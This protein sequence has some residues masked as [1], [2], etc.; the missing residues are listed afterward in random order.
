MG[1]WAKKTL[2][3][4]SS[5]LRNPGFVLG[6]LT[7]N[8]RLLPITLIAAV[9]WLATF[10]PGFWGGAGAWGFRIACAALWIWLAIALFRTPIQRSPLVA[11]LFLIVTSALWFYAIIPVGFASAVIITRSHALESTI[12]GAFYGASPN[13]LPRLIDSAGE[14]AVSR[15]S[16]AGIA[17][18][19]WALPAHHQEPSKANIMD[20]SLLPSRWLIIGL[21]AGS[22]VFYVLTRNN[23]F[24]PNVIWAEAVRQAN[25]AFLALYGA[26]I[27]LAVLRVVMRIEGAMVDLVIVAVAAIGFVPSGGAKLAVFILGTSGMAVALARRS[28]ILVVGAIAG[29]LAVMVAGV[30]MRQYESA[31][32]S[33]KINRTGSIL[34]AKVVARQAETTD[35]LTGVIHAYSDGREVPFNPFYFMAGLAPRFLWPDKPNLSAS[36]RIVIKYCDLN[37]RQNLTSNLSHS[38]SGTLLWEPLNFA[39][40]PGQIVAQTL[41]FLTLTLLSRIWINGG[42][43][44]AAGVLSLTPWAIDF[45]QHFALYMANLTKAGLVVSVALILLRWV[46]KDNS[47]PTIRPS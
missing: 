17:A 19:A 5:I 15:F 10:V 21:G 24:L 33:E 22:V 29:S 45:D 28:G 41:M 1:Y 26:M 39:G 44:A 25:F 3:K 11:P 34:A 4:S 12:F 7:P 13:L 9:V 14:L 8:P 43:Y 46:Y 31:S 47:D 16:L 40:V 30:V 36:G 37:I 35:C 2:N 27:G 6:H 32:L 18:L 23:Y 20:S 42:L 38:A